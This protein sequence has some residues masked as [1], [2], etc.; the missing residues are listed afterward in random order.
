MAMGRLYDHIGACYDWFEFHE[1]EA[2]RKAL[3]WLALEA[4]QH[5]LHIGVGSGRDHQALSRSVEPNGVAIGLDLSWSMASLTQKRTGSPICQADVRWLPFAEA[6]FDCLFAAYVL[7]LLPSEDIATVLRAFWRV[8]NPGGKMV[9]CSLT[10]GV[11]RL[12]R[13]V[14]ALWKMAYSVSPWICAGCRP[15]QLFDEVKKAGFALVQR[16]VVVQMGIPSEIIL[17]VKP[18]E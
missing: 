1:S 8:L 9:L 3:Q 6:S 4:G 13:R 7:D 16:Q 2:K 12:S 15:L 14:I 17:A 11:D 5:V 10:E 18:K